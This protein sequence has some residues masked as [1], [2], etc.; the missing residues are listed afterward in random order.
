MLLRK[1]YST[2][3]V[4]AIISS[5]P[6]DLEYLETDGNWIS[7]SVSEMF[8]DCL[9]TAGLSEEFSYEAGKF[10]MSPECLGN[11]Q[12]LLTKIVSLKTILVQAIETCRKFNR[13]DHIEILT[14][15]RGQFSVR[16]K[17]NRPTR[18]LTI[19]EK[20][21][22]GFLEAFPTSHGQPAKCHIVRVDETTSEF[23]VSWRE[24]A[25]LS[26]KHRLAA[27]SLAGFGLACFAPY[28]Y[29]LPGNLLEFLWAFPVLLA[30]VIYG[31]S[32]K[33][34]KQSEEDGQTLSRLV[35]Q[36]EKRYETLHESKMKL[37]RRYREANLLRG[38]VARITSSQSTRQLVEVTLKEIK[39]TLGFQRV[40][41]LEHNVKTNMLEV[42]GAAGFDENSKI[43][44]R[45]VIDLNEETNSS[46]HLGNIFKQGAARLVIVDDSY[47]QSLSP[48]GQYMLK[49][50]STNS[51]VAASVGDESSKF[52]LLLVDNNLEKKLDNDDLHVIRN[53]GNQLAILISNA[54]KL[55][56]ETTLREA[57]QKFVPISVIREMTSGQGG[58]RHHQAKIAQVSVL[59]SDIRGFTKKSD[60]YSASDL[61][62]ALNYYFT[63]MT[64]IVYKHG[65]IVDKFL[66]DGIMA[67]FNAFEDCPNHEQAALNCAA[68][69]QQSLSEI[70]R[71]IRRLSPQLKG[72]GELDIGIGIHSGPLI[73]GNIGSDQ[74]LEFT[75]IGKTVNIAARLQEL[76]KR[77][78]GIVVSRE[79]VDHLDASKHLISDLGYITVRGIGEPLEL[80]TVAE[81]K[82]EGREVA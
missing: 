81:V 38:V 21:W 43:V 4:R 67:L 58:V 17:S 10:S 45:Y 8:F 80:F 29:F 35:E 59:F 24:K 2:N 25:E 14:N 64:N 20:N 41:Y 60:L 46:L 16:V 51:F 36:H 39:D 44:E 30:V 73:V 37:D 75:A 52:G 40:V 70:S 19:I 26:W 28:I 63:E 5:L 53:L 1:K 15:S 54:K 42:F 7:E 62:E 48:L 23:F 33:A 55:E 31:F 68:A 13:V 12:Y 32:R 50:T 66:G 77:Y 56:S 61:V 9:Q 71:D 22:Q 78:P 82:E 34:Q 27:I 72:W 79:V 47:M 6:V 11:V 76:T 65:G 74:K 18:H 49:A 57:F 3:E 69:M